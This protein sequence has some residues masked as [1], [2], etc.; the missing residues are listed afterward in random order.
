MQSPQ[1]WNA[2]LAEYNEAVSMAKLY[3]VPEV[4]QIHALMK[5]FASAVANVAGPN[6]GCYLS[7]NRKI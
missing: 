5:D 7:G 3:G 1:H 4:L 6:V 2:W